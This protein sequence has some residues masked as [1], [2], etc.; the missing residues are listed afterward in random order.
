MT[1]AATVTTNAYR[2]TSPNEQDLKFSKSR[3]GCFI[4]LQSSCT[5][6]CENL[7]LEACGFPTMIS[8]SI[9]VLL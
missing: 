6:V 1:D 5:A 8:E 7:C 2:L 3:D 4:A 9:T